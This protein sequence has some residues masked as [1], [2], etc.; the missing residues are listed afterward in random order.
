[1]MT[2][3]AHINC[4]FFLAIQFWKSL[5]TNIK[6][7]ATTIF[8]FGGY[9]KRTL[10]YIFSQTNTPVEMDEFYSRYR[11]MKKHEKIIIDSRSNEINF[12]N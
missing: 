10:H 1:M 3:C 9:S 6:E 4:S 2:Q 8:Q 12:D 5:T 11:S 7:N